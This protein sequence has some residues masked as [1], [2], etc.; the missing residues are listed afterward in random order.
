M[1]G[2]TGQRTAVLPADEIQGAVI[3]PVHQIGPGAMAHIKNVVADLQLEFVAEGGRSVGACVFEKVD[4]AVHVPAEDIFLTLPVPVGHRG[5]APVAHREISRA[6]LQVLGGVEHG[7]RIRPLVEEEPDLA[8]ALPADHILAAVIVPV[9]DVGHG[10][11][12]T[13]EGGAAHLQKC[14]TV[15]DG[16]SVRVGVEVD[17]DVAVVLAENEILHSVVVPVHDAWSRADAS[18]PGHGDGRT[19]RFDGGAAVENG[20]QVR[21]LVQV[22]PDPAVI[23]LTHDQILGAI[24]VPVRPGGDGVEVHFE[25]HASVL[26][27]ITGLD[28]RLR[29]VHERRGQQ[30]H[31]T[32]QDDLERGHRN[33]FR[34]RN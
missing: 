23:D 29:S 18:A 31:H 9:K 20:I 13:I 5:C 12:P 6:G 16:I 26:D 25:V 7:I 32:N 21:A 8:V 2:I 15:K 11:I 3:V 28:G 17:A 14:K 4:V 10:I 22:E 1:D 34:N 33:S 24:V 30:Y 27:E 19:A